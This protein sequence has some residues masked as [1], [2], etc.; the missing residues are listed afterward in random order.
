MV[1]LYIPDPSGSRTLLVPYRGRLSKVYITPTPKD[2]Y[3]NHFHLFPPLRPGE[4]LGVNKRFW[5]MLV[6][7]LRIAI[8]S[9]TGKEA[10]LLLLH[11]FFLITRTILSVMV[12]RLD[13]RIVRDLVSA[14]G[15][16]FLRGLGWWFTLA[17][18]STYTNSM[19]RFLEKKLALAFRTNLTRYIHDLYLNQNLNYYKFGMGLAAAVPSG[20]RAKGDPSSEAASGGADQLITTDLAKFCDTLS[21]LYGNIGKPA[22]D[23]IIFTSQLSASLGPLGTVGLYS[24]YALT[25]WI[26]RKAT[27]AF[28]RM[29]AITATLEGEYRKGLSRIGRD[30]EEVAFYDGGK[31]EKGILLSAYQ[32]L[33]NHIHSVLK[34]RVPYG[35]TEDFVIKYAWS[36]CGYGLMSIPLLF[37]RA[38]HAIASTGGLSLH[39]ASRTENYVSNRRLLLSLAD[40]GGRLMYSGKDLAELSG[41]TTR[42]YSLLASLHAL[43]QNAYPVI[44]APPT[45]TGKP[46]YDL[47]SVKGQIIIG[48]DH[49][50]FKDVPIVAPSGG[51][52]AER[53]GEEL[54][55]SLDLRVEA[56]EHTLITGPNG[57]GKTSISRIA[58]QLWPTWSGLLERPHYGPGGIFFLPQRPYLSIGSLRDQVI[59]PQTYAEMK[60]Q[61][62]TDAELMQILENVH[63]AYLPSREGGWET[64]KEWKDVL[65]G[66]EKQRMGMARLFYHRPRY[67]IL[68]ECTSAV[69]S[70]VEGL[71]YEHAKTLG[72]TL[73]TISHRPSLLKYHTRHLRLG[74]MTAAKSS[75]VRTSSLESI[76]RT[77][78]TLHLASHGWQMT[79]VASASAQEN[80]ELDLEIEVLSKVLDDDVAQWEARLKQVQEQLSGKV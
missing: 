19:I 72:I 6:S 13:G 53:G 22:L 58:A 11:T 71:M 26:L 28:G 43:E 42:V 47:G 37:P 23:L 39:V 15:R 1:D 77:Q 69:S 32:R 56:V 31:R 3:E 49:L 50:L 2:L 24:N 41:Y 68:D 80:M 12:A 7:I 38:G 40:A 65:S 4:K 46:F 16:G 74:E 20:S 54:I 10:F 57:V 73:I 61:G 64:R 17:I 76:K 18:P 66:G 44:A 62:R 67:A 52:G 8:P 63:L 25:A 5:K 70:D 60:S 45:H 33:A 51:A 35:M 21:A 14:N 29:A 78:S 36:A 27:P 75:L 48:P 79:T 30:G 34:I 59:Y 55:R 9:S